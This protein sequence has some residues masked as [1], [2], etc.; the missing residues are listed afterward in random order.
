MAIANGDIVEGTIILIKQIKIGNL[1]LRD[2]EA[3]ITNTLSAPLLL[4][5]SAIKK[6]GT[7]TFDYQKQTITVKVK[8]EKN[9]D[10]IDESNPIVE[11]YKKTIGDG[12]YKKQV[13]EWGAYAKV[14]E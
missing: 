3:T 8:E 2:V 14:K 4:G 1:V 5:Q 11:A 7:F 13:A 6:F 12:V 10:I 9:E